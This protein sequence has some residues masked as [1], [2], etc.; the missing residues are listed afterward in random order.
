LLVTCQLLMQN[1]GSRYGSADLY[2]NVADPYQNVTG[3]KHWLMVLTNDLTA[4]FNFN[5]REIGTCDLV[6]V[7]S[8]ECLLDPLVSPQR[9]QHCLMEE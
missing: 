5:A 6:L 7:S 2:Q 4:F 1:A 9:G 8:A 3:P